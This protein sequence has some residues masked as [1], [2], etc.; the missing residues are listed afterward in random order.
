MFSFAAIQ[1][2]WANAWPIISVLLACSVFSGAVILERWFS[3]RRFD[4]DR[5]ALLDRLRKLLVE[6]KRESSVTHCENL[7]RPV[8]RI[9]AYVLQPTAQ[10]RAAGREYMERV[11]FRLIRTE[12]ARMNHYLI[13][14]GTIG[15]IAPFVG[16]LGTVV[17]IIHAFRAIA[18]NAGGGPGVVANG[19]AEA[20]ITT[21]LGLFVA[22]PAIVA[23]NAYGR[24]VERISEDMELCVQEV[25]DLTGAR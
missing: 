15:S 4:F 12:T 11:A 20:L 24:K 18:E 19:I 9:L 8:G 22:I 6:N 23:Y 2:M 25:L 21:A 3:L 17:G 5:D 10:D 14:L 7:R 13:V 1:E 16:L